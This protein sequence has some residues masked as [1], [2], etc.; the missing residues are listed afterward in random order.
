MRSELP[1]RSSPNTAV[2]LTKVTLRLFQLPELA[3]AIGDLTG[4]GQK[5]IQSLVR[6]AEKNIADRASAEFT[7][8]ATEEREWAEGL[9]ARTYIRLSQD[10]ARQIMGESLIGAD[11]LVRLADRAM[12]DV[13]RR[14]VSAASDNAQ[15]YLAALS[16][17]IAYLISEWYST[18]AEPNRAAISQA[19]GE[20][21]QTVRDIPNQL[22]TLKAYLESSLDP[23]LFRLEQS[24]LDVPGPPPEPEAERIVF[25][26][27]FG[28]APLATDAELT[29]LVTAAVV[30]VLEDRPVR[31]EV[32]LPTL[33]EDMKKFGDA[34]LA[35]QL[36]RDRQN[37]ARRFQLILSAFFS[38]Q[39]ETAWALYLGVPDRVTVVRAILAEQ[40]T[41]GAKLDVWRTTPPRVS[42][43]IWL[44]SDE[45]HAVLDSVEL[46]HWEHLRMGAGWR[47]ADELP[48]SIIVEKV[49]PSILA[50]LVR[51]E[52][53]SEE[54]WTAEV[55]FLR[56]W[57][58][59]Q[60]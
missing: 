25:E 47:S 34:V 15:A 16:G 26:L 36:K 57:H 60:G 33:D 54:D 31:I 39:I 46:G 6:M 29:D 50:E 53:I 20:T 55:L 42:A 49:I 41:T 44:T 18:N 22:E 58:I 9:L 10:P 48:R 30:T 3:D 17:S 19:V 52:V 2:A 14:E 59:G 37:K 40:E 1:G 23:V 5:T 43:P 4:L 35:A 21:L 45:V 11:A 24:T 8:V 32:T 27:D 28:F 13:D 12:A 51:T 56:S 38:P 7:A